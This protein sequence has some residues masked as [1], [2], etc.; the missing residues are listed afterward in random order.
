MRRTASAI[1]LAAALFLA[2]GGLARA[3]APVTVDT[4][5]G[6]VTVLADRIEEIGADN[7]VVATGNV[8]LTRGVTRLTAD[9]V[10]I[11]RQSGDAVAQGRA[12]FYDG[13][14]RLTGDRIDYNINTGTGVVYNGEARAAPYYRIGGERMERVGESVYRI[15]KGVFTTCEDD[16]PTWS[17]RF[18]NATADL[19]DLL[20][21]TNGSFWIKN[22]PVLPLV[23]I[24][25]A[26]LRRERET[27]F[28]F[29]RFGTTTRRGF[30]YEQPFFWAIS[31]SQDATI[32]PVI[33]EKRGV[34][35]YLEYNNVFSA[36]NQALLTGFFIRENEQA[37]PTKD[38]AGTDLNPP[39]RN[40]GF[41]G[42]KHD[43][44]LGPSLSL[45]AD[46]NGLSDDTVLREYSDRLHD[47][48]AQRV[49]SNI[50]LTKTWPNANLL[51]NTFWYQD[52]TQSRPVELYK[53]PEVRFQMPRQPV[54]GDRLPGFLYELDTQ[55]V[56]FV[57]EV[58][59]E[60][61]RLDFLP[62]ISRPIPV[63]GYFTLTPF[64][65]YRLTA[66]EKTVVGTR[67]T[68][69]GGIP[70][71]V[72]EDEPLLRRAAILG[73]DVESRA[74]RIYATGGW[75]GIDAV[76]HAIEPRANY[77]FVDGTNLATTSIPQFDGV[78]NF[79][80]TSL[81]TYS[82]TNRVIARTVAPA[83]TE[84]VRFE[85]LRFLVAHSYNFRDDV[86][87]LG[88]ITGDLLVNPNRI[89]TF[90]ADT[91][92]NLYGDGFV[93]G[94]TDVSVSVPRLT[95]GVGTRY[96]KPNNFLQGNFRGEVTRNLIVRGSTNWDVQTDTFVENRLA[97][98]VRFQC[99][100][101]SVEYVDRNRNEDEIRF[102]VN[103]LGLGAPITTSAGLGPLLPGLAPPPAVPGTTPPR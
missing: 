28:L 30:F 56:N 71:E 51:V 39:D 95:A 6:P 59:S 38:A 35:G 53:L 10:E 45:K 17:F 12:I 99:W 62:R 74:S 63:F 89:L 18:G 64:A 20:Y 33:Y 84:P 31:D 79:P 1:L 67:L 40:R 88:N 42:Y 78:D 66:Y 34:G 55:F 46:I 65:A 14:D 82:L 101:I 21:G 43:W 57:R 19:Q 60:A 49:E 29:P 100:A 36:T 16:P 97:V 3:Q 47:R 8:E 54:P 11:N 83:G 22:V 24:F 4:P 7:L 92:Y 98:D 2:G 76:L 61:A 52:L 73:T 81:L 86:R 41:W 25:A 96:T 26:S 102:A 13:D 72:T 94:N 44:L 9:R 93:T 48:S 58:G 27:G 68:R 23:P 77:T 87:P 69:A 5:G 85:A 15:R 103:L 75:G 37:T 90:R 91:S 32:T 80:E 70:V 50:F